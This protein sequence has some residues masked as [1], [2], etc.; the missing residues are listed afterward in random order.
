MAITSDGQKPV[1][2]NHSKDV[3][4]ESRLYTVMNKLQNEV[5]HICSYSRVRDPTSDKNL[6]ER[7]VTGKYNSLQA[8]RTDDANNFAIFLDPFALRNPGFS[9]ENVTESAYKV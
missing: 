4:H 8:Y 7:F 1:P 5:S 2:G 3:S 6:L 9:V